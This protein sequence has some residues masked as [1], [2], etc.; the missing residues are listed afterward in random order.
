VFGGGKVHITLQDVVQFKDP[1]GD[2]GCILSLEEDFDGVVLEEQLAARQQVVLL[3]AITANLRI[4]N[5]KC[6]RGS[7][8]RE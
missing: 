1:S 6:E 3:F 5:P 2:V 7:D 4:L 8:F